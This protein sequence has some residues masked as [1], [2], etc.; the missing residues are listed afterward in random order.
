MIIDTHAH[1]DDEQYN[2]DRENLLREIFSA[3]IGKIVNSGATVQ[4]TKDSVALA[5]TFEQVYAT[6]GVHPS[7]IGEVTE[8]FYD[9]LRKTS[10]DKKVVAIGEIGLDYYWE[11]DPDER[12]RQKEVFK[13]QLDLSYEVDLPVVIHS[14]DAAE[15]TMKILKE[16]PKR[17]IP[18]IIHCYAYSVEM[19]R[20]YV[21]MGYYLGVGG[22]V[23]FKNSRVLKEVVT[24]IGVEH[25]VLETDCPYLAP[26]PHRG[27]RNNSQNLTYVVEK[28]AE[29]TGHSVEEVE[30]ITTENAC[31]VYGF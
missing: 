30:R 15:D 1:Y 5:H 9:Y 18:G 20:E 16:A 28:I 12:Q 3:K 8:E 21:K 23:T 26:E 14:R 22:V 29:L 4:S 7:E 6:I 17:E 27:T 19:A 24:E 31:R 10:K 13:R 2:D 25:L 11:K